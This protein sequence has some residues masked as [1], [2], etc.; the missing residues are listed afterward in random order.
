MGT[1]LEK[2]KRQKKKKEKASLLCFVFPSRAAPM[3]YGR[4]QARGQI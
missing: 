2:A 1:A 3:A 4:S